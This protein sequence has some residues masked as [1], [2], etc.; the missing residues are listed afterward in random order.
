MQERPSNQYGRSLL[1]TCANHTGK[2]IFQKQ[3]QLFCVTR[4]NSTA[5]ML[6]SFLDVRHELLGVLSGEEMESFL[7]LDF[8]LVNDMHKDVAE[9]RVFTE[10]LS[11]ENEPT[12]HFVVPSRLKLIQLSAVRDDDHPALQLLIEYYKQH[13]EEYWELQNEYWLALLCYPKFRQL[14]FC[15]RKQEQDRWLAEG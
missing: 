7:K 13:I 15:D 4:W 10:V 9:F 11:A 12:L 6:E 8:D 3:L 5:S 1:L 14:H 2:L